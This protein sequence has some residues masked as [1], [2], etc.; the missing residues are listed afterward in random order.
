MHHKEGPMYVD[1]TLRISLGFP[2][3]LRRRLSA[4]EIGAAPVSMWTI[5]LF[6]IFDN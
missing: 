3:H 5:L 6:N 4:A 1:R 2:A